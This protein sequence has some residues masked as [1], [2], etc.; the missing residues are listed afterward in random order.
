MMARTLMVA[1]LAASTSAW[2]CWDDDW[3][4]ENERCNLQRPPSLFCEDG[5]Q[6]HPW[7]RC[8]GRE[9]CCTDGFE[10]RGRWIKS[11]KPIVG[12]CEPVE[13]KVCDGKTTCGGITG[14]SC[15]SR[16]HVCIDNP[17]DNCDPAKGGRDCGGCCVFNLCQ[18]TLC[19]GDSVCQLDA[20]GEPECVQPPAKTCKANGDCA[21]DEFCRPAVGGRGFSP[22]L[23][24]RVCAKKGGHGAKC[25]GEVLPCFEERCQDGLRCQQDG[26][27]D[28][29]GTCVEDVVVPPTCTPFTEE[30]PCIAQAGVCYNAGECKC[31]MYLRAQCLVDPCSVAKCDSGFEC[32]SSNCGGCHHQCVKKE[33]VICCQAVPTCPS[34]FEQTEEASC[35]KEMFESKICVR[36]ALCCKEIVCKA[37]PRECK[38]DAE[39]PSDEFCK[40]QV[41]GN[42][43]SPCLQTSTCVKRLGLGAG[44]GGRTL[45][46]FRAE[47]QKGLRCHT[48]G[49]DLPGTC[50]E[51]VVVP[52][53]CTPFT[54]EKPC[55]AQAGVCYNAGE[56]KCGM[57]FKSACKVDP[58]TTATCGEGFECKASY[59][60]G[61]HHQCV[62]KEPVICC[63]AVPTCPSGFEQTEEA[64]C[65]KQ[66]FESKICVRE[67]LCCKE[68]V[69]KAAP[70][71]CKEDAEC[72]SDE[73]CKQQVG[74]NG[75]SP[76][77]QTSTCVKRLGLGAD[78]GGRTLPCFRAECQKGLRCHTEGNDLP[79]TCVEDVVVPP[80]CT[81]F[82]EEK[83]C[84]AQE[85]VCYNAG[86]CKCG[87]YFKSEC[88]VDPC[89][90][91]TCGEG[92]ECKASYCGGCHHQCVA[93][94][95]KTCKANGDCAKDEFCR[96]AVGGRGFSPCLQ[97]RVCAKKGGH[98][99]KCGGE[100]LPCFEERCQDGL[101]CQ[102]DGA[103]DAPGTCVEDV[104]VPPTC[105]PFT[106][107]KPCIAQA[108]VCYNAGECKCGMYLRAQ[109]LVDPCSVA[110][111]DSGFECRSSN[112]GGCHHQCV[113]KEPVICCQAVPTCPSGFEQTEEASC[114]KQMFESKIC[115]REALCCK[116]IVCR[117]YIK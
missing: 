79:G 51:D 83:P 21:K 43:V 55:I 62:K 65:T 99:A 108:G 77:L 4:L 34:G 74:G 18:V 7:G 92:F 101:R 1:A 19:G 50:V 86:E 68:I 2:R 72:P 29:P 5:P 11:C 48:E 30:K 102:Q 93:V 76:C 106:E 8:F 59:C 88:K 70:R 13:A 57:Y 27:S 104:V 53:T 75:V 96:P 25:G 69:C 89:T 26:A 46:C 52:P 17:D 100:V 110:K 103:S 60:G 73:F 36:E 109:C 6:I 54:E 98:G 61:C 33:P 38:E 115:V 90:T 56:C 67:A 94:Q 58:C 12:T 97:E 23:Q 49:N 9:N 66:M 82:T 28:A 37:A 32:R 80:T 24:E 85:G 35:T 63:Q 105:T 16:S 47:C 87:M 78:C 113:K 116:E 45:P 20:Q 41:G 22:C 112:C 114:T 64:S 111:C 91:A 42:G 15:N 81:P 95:A 44:C 39:C 10:C 40:Q 14:A 31:G 3:C 107:E 117:T 71:E 84:I